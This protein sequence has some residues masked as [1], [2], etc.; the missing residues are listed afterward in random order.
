MEPLFY[1]TEKY[2]KHII[3]LLKVMMNRLNCTRVNE[4][5]TCY[6]RNAKHI[7]NIYNGTFLYNSYDMSRS[8]EWNFEGVNEKILSCKG[9][10]QKVKELICNCLDNL[11]LSKR[12]DYM[13]FSKNYVESIKF[14]NF[15]ETGRYNCVTS[16]VD[17]PFLKFVNKP[18]K[19][20]SYQSSL[21]FEDVK[22]NISS[23][24]RNAAEVIAASCFR[25]D[26]LQVFIVSA[27]EALSQ[28]IFAT[29]LFNAKINSEAFRQ[30]GVR[31]HVS[32]VKSIPAFIC[33]LF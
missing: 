6:K 3:S 11:E 2:D 31:K 19:K 32:C 8:R 25:E 18:V 13:P 22:K 20:F 7:Q 28:D 24:I 17:S 10:W 27:N 23:S 26:L 29:I 1:V 5:N 9:S 4:E 33:V 15:F 30:M 14:S 16:E 12:T 21:K